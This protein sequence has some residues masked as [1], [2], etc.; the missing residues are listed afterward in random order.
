MSKYSDKLCEMYPD[1]KAVKKATKKLIKEKS[2]LAFEKYHSETSLK[3]LKGRI[4]E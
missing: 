2:K 1:I 3:R 4:M